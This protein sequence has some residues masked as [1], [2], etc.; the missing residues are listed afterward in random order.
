MRSTKVKNIVILILAAVDIF[1]LILVLPRAAEQRRADREVTSQIVAILNENNI[2]LT[3]GSIPD[4]GSVRIVTAVRD[5]REEARAAQML[6]GDAVCQDLGGGIFTYTGTG[7]RVTFRAGGEF[8]AE[9]TTPQSG[10]LFSRDNAER[11]L[12]K[13][14]IQY[15]RLDSLTSGGKTALSA[16]LTL[17]GTEIYGDTVVLV[18]GEGG[19]ESISGHWYSNGSLA[20]S[21]TE[22]VSISTAL[23]SFINSRD[24]LGY[25]FGEITGISTVYVR[26]GGTEI[27]LVPAWRIITDAGE[28]QV[29]FLTLQV[30][31]VG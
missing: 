31:R 15:C 10:R 29:S 5:T 9:I 12:K 3:P 28:F 24:Q 2:S 11:L 1:L 26:S 18:Y 17:G 19:L 7:G 27:L 21:D 4:S 6:L 14:G 23:L 20:Y 22:E 8:E 25:V 30:T 13:L 16:A